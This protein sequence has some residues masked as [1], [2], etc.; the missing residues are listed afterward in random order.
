MV[1][2]TDFQEQMT[3]STT[4]KN[5]FKVFFKNH[6]NREKIIYIYG[7]LNDLKWKRLNESHLFQSEA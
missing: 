5:I 3:M 6:K 1:P 7:L 2:K 4:S